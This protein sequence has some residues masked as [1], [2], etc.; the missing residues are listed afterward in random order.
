[1][2][3]EELA[4]KLNGRQVNKEISRNEAKQA[5]ADGLVVVY[6]ASD[7]LVEFDGAIEDEIEAY[8]GT[9]IL[10]ADGKIFNDSACDSDCEY[11]QAARTAAK[12]R[13][14]SIEAFWCEDKPYCWTFVTHIPHA[15]FDIFEGKEKFCRG[16]VFNLKNQN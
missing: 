3:K 9:S 14:D 7:D 12:T 4:A 15:V 6:G 2:T 5:K 11:F 10:I 16:I 13:G 1:M 8:G